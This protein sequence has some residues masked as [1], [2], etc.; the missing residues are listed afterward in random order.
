MLKNNYICAL[1]IGSTKIA[2]VAAEIKKKK[3]SSVFFVT[4]P[5]KGIK[6]GTIVNSV[7]LVGSI[8]QALDKLRA[9]SGINIKFVYANISGRDIVTSHAQAIIP[10]AERGNKVIMPSDIR[11]V[12][13]QAR[14]LGSNLDEEIIHQVPFSY[15]I[16]SKN[17]IANPLGLYSHKLEVDLYLICGKLASI[18]SL[19]RAVNQ[20]GAEIKNLFFSGIATAEAVLSN[21]LKKGQNILCDIGG[22]VTEI[23]LFKDGL[24]RHTEV[25]EMGGDDLTNALCEELK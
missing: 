17:K 24:L 10:L 22:D 20:A 21:E 23:L 8:E 5:V 14:I 9:A 25:L 13:E 12:T 18:Q 15:S 11:K 7:E 4:S 16:D 19:I 3:V 2:A 1:D 6:K